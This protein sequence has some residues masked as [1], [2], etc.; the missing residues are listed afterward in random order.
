MKVKRKGFNGE[1]GSTKQFYLKYVEMVETLQQLH[2]A[3]NT[4]SLSL[5]LQP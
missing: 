1:F 2:F 5:K 3:L 4:N